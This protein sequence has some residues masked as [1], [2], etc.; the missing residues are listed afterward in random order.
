MLRVWGLCVSLQ[1]TSIL[2]L[3]SLVLVFFKLNL[4]MWGSDRF[5]TGHSKI[6][7]N[8]NF[9]ISLKLKFLPKRH[10]D[11]ALKV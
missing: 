4:C 3:V 1:V 10:A 2:G 11:D 7:S 6:R 8:F 9:G 5:S